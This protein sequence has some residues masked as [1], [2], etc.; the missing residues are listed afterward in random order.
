MMTMTANAARTFPKHSPYGKSELKTYGKGRPASYKYSRGRQMIEAVEKK[1]RS[2][3]P[4]DRK[5]WSSYSPRN[6][7]S[8]PEDRRHPRSPEQ[9][10]HYNLQKKR[11]ASEGINR[12]GGTRFP[13][14]SK[15]YHRKDDRMQYSS[16]PL[17]LTRPLQKTLRIR[18]SRSKSRSPRRNA[19][20]TPRSLFASHL[21]PEKARLEEENKENKG[22]LSYRDSSS[23]WL[24]SPP[25]FPNDQTQCYRNAA[26]QALFGLEPFVQDLCR[27]RKNLPSGEDACAD[28]RVLAELVNVFLAREAKDK[29][30]LDVALRR[31][32]SCVSRKS[33]GNFCVD[34][35]NDANEYLHLLLSCLSD[36]ADKNK[37]LGDPEKE[38][39]ATPPPPPNS[40]EPVSPLEINP[41]M[42]NFGFKV[43]KTLKCESC[44][45]E[46]KKEQEEEKELFLN[47]GDS[48]GK[49]GNL[50][51]FLNTCFHDEVV[52]RKCDN[53]GCDGRRTTVRTRLS[54]LPRILFLNLK[55]YEYRDNEAHKTIAKV[56][57]P[58]FLSVE[59]IIPESGVET[60]MWERVPVSPMKPRDVISSS[61]HT[62]DS[63]QTAPGPSTPTANSVV[64]LACHDSGYS[65]IEEDA[66]LQRAVQE[67]LR[68]MKT[69]VHDAD[70][71]P[72]ME[73]DKTEDELKCDAEVNVESDY[74][75]AVSGV[76]SG[77]R[78]RLVGVISHVGERT[79]SGHYTADVYKASE[80]A[81]YHC[82]DM[83]VSKK[84]EHTVLNGRN[85]SQ[86]YIFF[87][88]NQNV[89]EVASGKNCLE[90]LLEAAEPMSPGCVASEHQV[91][92]GGRGRPLRPS[93]EI[94][95]ARNSGASVPPP[96]GGAAWLV[97]V[98]GFFAHA[99]ID[100][101][102]V[103][104]GILMVEL[105]KEFD[106]YGRAVVAGIGSLMVGISLSI[107]PVSAAA[108]NRFGLRSCALF[109]CLTGAL[110]ILL[111]SYAQHVALLFIFYGIMSGALGIL[112]SSYAQHVALLFIFYG[113]MSGASV[114]M[115]IMTAVVAPSF[116]FEKRRALATGLATCGSG[117]GMLVFPPLQQMLFQSIGWRYALMIDAALVATVS[118]LC[119]SMR[120][121]NLVKPLPITE[122]IM[123]V[124]PA[125]GR[126]GVTTDV[127]S[128]SAHQ[129]AGDRAKEMTSSNIFEHCLTGDDEICKALGAKESLKTLYRRTST[130][131][132]LE[133][134]LNVSG[135]TSTLAAADSQ[136]VS[137]ISKA[138]DS[139]RKDFIAFPTD[140]TSCKLRSP[141]GAEITCQKVDELAAS[142]SVHETERFEESIASD[143]KA[144]NLK[145]GDDSEPSIANPRLGEYIL[146]SGTKPLTQGTILKELMSRYRAQTVPGMTNTGLSTPAASKGETSQLSPNAFEVGR[147]NR[148]MISNVTN[149]STKISK[150]LFRK[151]IFYTGS[152][153]HLAE[154]QEKGSMTAY[155]DSV[156]EVPDAA[157]K[158]LIQAEV[159]LDVEQTGKP[160]RFVAKSRR[161][162]FPEYLRTTLTNLLRFSLLKNLAFR[163]FCLSGFLACLG[164]VVAPCYLADL[165]MS[166]GY[167]LQQ[168]ALGLSIIGG[169]NTIGRIICGCLADSPR[170]KP[171]GLYIGAFAVCGISTAALPFATNSM[172]TMLPFFILYGLGFATAVMLRSILLVKYVGLENL[173][174]AFG[175][176]LLFTGVATAIAPPLAGVIHTYAGDFTYVFMVAG[177]A[178]F[179]GALT[180]IPL[181]FIDRYAPNQPTM[182]ASSL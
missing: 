132:L 8:T 145:K 182:A 50:R 11:Y 99:V 148:S 87:Y 158:E 70:E 173:T 127:K 124:F 48:H 105:M 74:D 42:S 16:K 93:N 178:M 129:K 175:L 139:E 108:V 155:R 79:A 34:R 29:E 100:G 60:P 35:M 55:R 63:Q 72:D 141:T 104:Y 163:Y 116:Y 179:I 143:I 162:Y 67:S 95:T 1:T 45:K 85:L 111:S 110:G 22:W 52:D 152:I 86:G 75:D 107:G 130:P 57:I 68:Y 64:D 20:P 138:M 125:D 150:P 136:R 126:D 69:P 180:L 151:D 113:I 103:S 149:F 172:I 181:K 46:T 25:G 59:S 92:P 7:P 12:Q 106:G 78:Y 24:D 168:G 115:V 142:V 174:S 56:V 96:D 17:S 9:S 47:M 53:D 118:P 157:L 170:T 15:S 171:L 27:A 65:S 13:S 51:D 43:T 97:V 176:Y 32:N 164:F 14:N 6:F 41:I 30:K 91:L 39:K 122:S 61:A 21:T 135:G 2:S 101:I 36:L 18:R 26:L 153:Q 89:L 71:S 112:L 58:K 133:N 84:N 94:S 144:P 37:R 165:M 38:A 140:F 121:L 160:M 76:N 128:D 44:G 98:F 5:Q 28:E 169:F 49:R 134:K 3:G 33:C 114:G 123:S 131:H 73:V 120:P 177:I 10:R 154:F 156:I 83:S 31:L 81:W 54:Q 62:P 102:I 77:L 117:I 4:V 19:S 80:D 147:R 82:D 167:T 23:K 166:R 66:D 119:V 90:R 137:E 109:G 161:R 159:V 88:M 146:E 40:P